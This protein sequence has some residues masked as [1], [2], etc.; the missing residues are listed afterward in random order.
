MFQR[1]PHA[2]GIVSHQQHAR[3]IPVQMARFQFPWLDL[4]RKQHKIPLPRQ[5]GGN[6]ME[7]VHQHP[8]IRFTARQQEKT[9]LP[10]GPR[11]R[12]A[13]RCIRSE[14]FQDVQD[15]FTLLRCNTAGPA[16]N[17]GDCRRRNIC[18][19]SDGPDG[20]FHNFFLLLCAQYSNVS[21]IFQ[22]FVSQNPAF[23]LAMRSGPL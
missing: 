18:Q 7:L 23:F 5:F 17:T 2:A 22:V 4:R 3:Q 8:G 1:R 12:T 9:D 21:E 13:A 19:F 14:L 11:C 16:Q 20:M 6:H 10:P 15:L